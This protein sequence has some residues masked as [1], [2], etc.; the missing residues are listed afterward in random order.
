MDRSETIIRMEVGLESG[1]S[2]TDD[3]ELGCQRDD[4]VVKYVRWE[5]IMLSVT[6]FCH[7]R[8]KFR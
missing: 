5:P 7:S 4:G 8:G 6:L 1:H 3:M 2:K